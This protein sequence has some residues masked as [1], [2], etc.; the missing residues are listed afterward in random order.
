V[1]VD[2]EEDELVEPPEEL[3]RPK[4]FPKSPVEPELPEAEEEFPLL[5][6][7]RLL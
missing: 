2:E 7:L 4:R 6:P 5:V 3:L 1:P